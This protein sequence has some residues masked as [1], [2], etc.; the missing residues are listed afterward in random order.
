MRDIGLYIHIPFCLRRC[1]YCDFNAYADPG[2]SFRRIYHDALLTDL[3]SSALDEDY[4]L[5]SVYIG[6]GTPSLCPAAW[7][8]DIMDVCRRTFVWPDAGPEVSIEANPGTVT[9][10]SLR[11]M[12]QAGIN[13]IS[14]GIQ[15]LDDGLLAMLGRIHSRGEA[16]QSVRWACEAGFD[17]VSADLMYGLPRQTVPILRSTV[18]EIADLGLQHFS[19]YALSV[20]DGTPL[21]RA[22]ASGSLSL[23]DEDEEAAL[24]QVISE[25]L[26][27]CGYRHYEISNWSYPGYE[28]L[29][30][31]IYWDNGEYLGVGCGAV[32]YL[33][34]WRFPRL[35]D[36]REYV[37]AVQAGEFPAVSGERLGDEARWRETL[38]LGLRR[39]HGVDLSLLG[40]RFGIPVEK[41]WV[42][43]NEVPSELWVKRGTRVALTQQGWNLSN[44][45]F[46]RFFM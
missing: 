34:G 23:P 37:R 45:I 9:L 18:R 14:F 40:Q 32:S 27:S 1:A 41:L 3:R 29:H 42:L 10:E 46:V 17:N 36:V 12:R 31:E 5:R 35:R 20:E 11:S 22:L 33:R 21:Q 2:L 16:L 13:R 19:A 7:L 8:A 15:S 28:C 38:M 39:A 24:Q 4:R 43:W 44:E 26:T 30:N 6:G 25:E